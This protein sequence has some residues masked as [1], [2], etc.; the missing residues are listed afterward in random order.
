MRRLGKSHLDDFV[1]RDRGRAA[2]GEGRELPKLFRREGHDLHILAQKRHGIHRHRD[3]PGAESEKAAEFDNDFQGSATVANDPVHRSQNILTFY[4]FQ[5]VPVQQIA[6]THRLR[7]AHRRKLGQAHA[8]R[9]HSSRCR[10]LR[11]GGTAE[12]N[13]YTS[14]A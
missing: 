3:R 11:V 6:D 4:R 2:R 9:R 10:T 8:R 12:G 5:H 7:K 14:D 1:G 13:E